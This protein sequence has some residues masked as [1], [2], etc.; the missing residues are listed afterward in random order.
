MDVLFLSR[1]QFAITIAFHYIYPPLSIGLGIL[2]VVLYPVLFIIPLI[3]ML[4]IANIPREIYHGRDLLALLSSCV[5]MLALLF[6][7][8][9]GLFPN[10]VPSNPD[11]QY[12]LTIYN[13]VSSPKFLNYML[14]IAVLGSW[15][16]RL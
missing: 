4:S 13:S 3:N 9:I 2:L 12:S 11:P 7:C 1:I 5:A 6:L 8:G 16:T 14:N 10:I 15:L